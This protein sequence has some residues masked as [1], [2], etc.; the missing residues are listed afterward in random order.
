MPR[1]NRLFDTYLFSSFVEKKLISLVILLLLIKFSTFQLLDTFIPFLV[2]WFVHFLERTGSFK[3]TVMYQ[4]VGRSS[5]C[6]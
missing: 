4:Y 2:L 6:C 3:F 1:K 5:F